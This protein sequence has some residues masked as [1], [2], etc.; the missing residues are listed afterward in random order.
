MP[1][2][3]VENFLALMSQLLYINIILELSIVYQHA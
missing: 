3:C 2:N 1:V